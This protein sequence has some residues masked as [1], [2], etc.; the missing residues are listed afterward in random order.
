MKWLYAKGNG[1]SCN[2]CMRTKKKLVSNVA[3]GGDKQIEMF[4]FARL[5]ALYLHYFATELGED[6][7][8]FTWTLDDVLNWIL[9]PVVICI[10][11]RIQVGK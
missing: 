6:M 8:I 2:I 10:Q 9:V 11:L 4:F 1:S 3:G 7:S 5:S